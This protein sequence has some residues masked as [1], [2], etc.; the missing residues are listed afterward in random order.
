MAIGLGVGSSACGGGGYSSPTTPTPNPTPLEP[1]FTSI[2]TQVLQPRCVSACHTSQ[3]RVPEGGLNLD[4]AVAYT[5]LVNVPSVG[6]P[7]LLRV[8]P[9]NSDQ[10]YMIHKLEGRAGI[11]GERMPLGGPFLSTA[12]IQ[13]IRQWIDAGAQNN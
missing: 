7:A 5:S 10:S 2:R 4:A 12:Q 1:N 13:V 3:G 9:G 6:R 11:D 8:A